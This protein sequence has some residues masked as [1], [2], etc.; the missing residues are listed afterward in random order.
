LVQ[1]VDWRFIFYVNLPIGIMG[2]IMASRLLREGPTIPN[3]RFDLRGFALIGTGL[4]L[5][6]YGFSNLTYDGWGSIKTVSGPIM[7]AVVLFAIFIPVQ[8]ITPQPLLELRLFKSRNFL[9]GN[10]IIWLATIGLMGP[11]FLLPQYLQNLRGLDAYSAGLLLLPN[12]LA[13]MAG[14]ILSGVLYNRIGPKTLILVGGV[15]TAFDSFLIGQWSTLTSMYSF[16]LPLLLVRGFCLP[17][18][19]QTPSNVALMGISGPQLPRATTLSSVSRS[20]MASLSI[21]MLSNYLTNKQVFHRAVLSNSVYPGNFTAMGVYNQFV[22]FFASHGYT[23]AQAKGLAIAQFTR[24][25]GLQAT[26][27]AFQDVYLLVGLLAIPPLLL[28]FFLRI[29]PTSPAAS[30]PA[31]APAMD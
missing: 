4:F 30:A 21:A 11:A 28:T 31:A 10:V 16:L 6:L 8:L 3:L 17:W 26:A 1:Y 2:V 13:A 15:V 25:V 5:F 29:Q 18:L 27:L 23:L 7:A 20:V 12:G 22:A 9:V 19:A 14:T 24:L